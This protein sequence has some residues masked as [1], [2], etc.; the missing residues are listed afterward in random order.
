VRLPGARVNNLCGI[1]GRLASPGATV[2]KRS[3]ATRQ[4]TGGHLPEPL[5]FQA[6]QAGSRTDDSARRVLAT[7]PIGDTSCG[8]PQRGL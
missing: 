2:T 8:H 6:S 4:G 5:N 7:C 3:A 1:L